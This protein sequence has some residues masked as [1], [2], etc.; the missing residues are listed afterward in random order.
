MIPRRRPRLIVLWS[1]QRWF[2]LKFMFS[3]GV[4]LSLFG[5]GLYIWFSLVIDEVL[6][7]L[8]DSETLLRTTIK[9]ELSSAGVMIFGFLV[10]LL[11]VAIVQS[12]MFGRAIAEPLLAINKR[13]DEFRDTRIFTPIRL[14]RKDKLQDLAEKINAAIQ[15]NR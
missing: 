3:I 7:Q 5:V 8:P 1:F 2:A 10:L 11:A 15:N 13:L 12:L 14:R 4:L 6:D 9:T